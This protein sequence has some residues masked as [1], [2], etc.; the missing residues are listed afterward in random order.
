MKSTVSLSLSLSIAAVL[1]S[2]AFAAEAAPQ[3][4]TSEAD[5]GENLITVVGTGLPERVDQSGQPISV[6]NEV[7]IDQVQGSELTRVLERLPGVVFSRNGGPGGATGVRVRG[8]ASEQL[9]VL[10]DG[11]RTDDPSLPS[12]GTNFG[13][14]LVGN[15]E[16]VELLRGSNSVIWGSQ[17]I[18]GVMAL[19]TRQLEGARLSAEYGTND[20]F[21]GSAAAGGTAGI[22]SGTLAAGYT[23]TDGFSEIAGDPEPDGYRQW[24]ISG[25]GKLDAGSGLA[26]VA[27]GRFA[28]S[29]REIDGFGVSSTDVQFTRD[30]S[31]GTG[32]RYTGQGALDVATNFA[33]YDI[34]RRYEGPVLGGSSYQGR[35]YRADIGGRWHIVDSVSLIFGGSYDWNRFSDYLTPERSAGQTSFHA[36][37]DYQR[38][39]LGLAAG[40]RYDHHD[41][42]G[43]EWTFGA[44]GSYEFAPGFRV[45]A[46]YGEGFKTP[47]LYQIYAPLQSYV[48]GYD[49]TWWSSG[50]AALT[51]EHSRSYDAGIEYGS[52]NDVLHLAVSVFRRDSHDLIDFVSCDMTSV[53][54]CAENVGNYHFA[55][56]GNIGS[57]RAEGGEVEAAVRPVETLTVQALYSYAKTWD[58]TPGGYTEGRDLPRRPRHSVT[59]AA[60]WQT[61][62]QGLTLGA[63]MRYVSGSFDS[64][65]TDDRLSGYTVATLRASLPVTEGVELFGR[66]ENLFDE[67]YQTAKG[68]GTAGRS[69]YLGARARF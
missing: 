61:P 10:V 15:V 57:T 68:Y 40:V 31:F 19:T 22:F 56:Y 67:T 63:D 20:S 48:D 25:K 13:N 52:R 30:L 50:N 69:A 1:A 4:A 2:P 35:T 51:P 8:A 21:T 11:V 28:D 62:L 3:V 46:S 6:I 53:G 24:E 54:L 18:G 58:R 12:G 16:K 14:L 55:T 64:L 17:A 5:A 41:T 39:G 47:S 7:T 66:I 9:L 32:M 37:L 33:V 65:Y 43:G 38:G 42:F 27:N 34:H 29:R 60:D 44:N 49:V 26:L 23:R 59:L 36:L 45:R